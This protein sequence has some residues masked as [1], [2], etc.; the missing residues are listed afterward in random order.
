MKK[1]LV[2]V[3][4]AVVAI[5]SPVSTYAISSTQLDMFAQ[6][7]ILFYDPDES[8]T[9]ETTPNGI[10]K[11]VQYNLTDEEIRGFA[12]M[13]KGENSCNT[14]AFRTELSQMANLYERNGKNEGIVKY[15]TRKPGKP[16]NG[17]ENGWYATYQNFNNSSISV[18]DE[19]FKIAKDV[20]VNG[21]RNL[22][23]QVVEHDC[24]GDIKWVELNGV[25]HESSGAG[26]CA[27][28]G[29]SDKSLYVSGK[30]KIHTVYQSENEYYIFYRFAG[31]ENGCGDP[32]GYLPGNVPSE[33]YSTV[34][35][36]NVNYAGV[37]VWSDAEMQAIEAN[38]AIYE[39]AAD[40]YGISWQILAVLHSHETS[41]G[42]RNPVS[43]W[44]NEKSEGVYGLHSWAVSGRIS[45][46]VKEEI[47]DDEFLQQTIWAAEFVKE[48]YG[49]LNLKT[50]DG[51]KTMFY[52]FNGLGNPYYHDK[53]IALGFGEEGAA[54][55]EGSPY[56]MNRY[57]EQ[58][59]PTSANMNSA[60]PGRFVKD[61][62]YDAGAVAN[63]FGAFVQYEALKGSSYC[64]A[65]GGIIAET[66]IKLSW[67]GTG[68]DKNNPKPEYV[69]AM[70]EI[71]YYVKGNGYYPEGASCDQFVGTVMRYS[72]AD[73]DFPIFF[74]YGLVKYLQTHTEKYMK[75]D[76]QEDFS[77][78]QPGDIFITYANGDHIY[79][80]VG[81]I[82][83]KMYQASA[84]ANS[85]TG[86]HFASVYFSDGH[87]TSGDGIRHYEVYRRINY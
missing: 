82:D 56:V 57:D 39:K 43:D 79:L 67:E 6:N 37:Q 34:A 58:R 69:T 11:G 59:D 14:V 52:R 27:G 18:S 55:G 62:V 63:N 49:D 60:W 42:R 40:Q 13:A 66:A 2:V 76:H 31:G 81:E 61:G 87:G 21:N 26:N 54:I 24:I 86:E 77:K 8:T 71:G 45:I 51:V 15:I 38:K 33:S 7:N 53:A 41:L 74:G 4:S 85:R 84:S 17:G 83:G 64:S 28:Q 73:P 46:D 20:L 19:E 16:E 44:S 36:R 30:T 22:P 10:Y 12:R 75:V 25:K 50:D 72:K 47:S 29:L 1:F 3:V 78:L 70:K 9:C 65:A 23:P 5:I 48:N 68:H 32:F 35:G 80:Y